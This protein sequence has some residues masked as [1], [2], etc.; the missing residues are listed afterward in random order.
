MYFH[1]RHLHRSA[2]DTTISTADEEWIEIASS[3]PTHANTVT[4]GSSS[5]LTTQTTTT[6]TTTKTTTT[7]TTTVENRDN[8]TLAGLPVPLLTLNAADDPIIH[9]DTTPCQSGVVGVVDNLICLVTLTGG[10][11]GWPLTLFPWKHK[12]LFQNSLILEYC[13]AIVDV[14]NKS[15]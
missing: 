6:M 1:H 4:V 11:V 14:K 15:K 5:T 12:F 2:G 10:H 3:S 7:T 8:N 13:Q 9:V